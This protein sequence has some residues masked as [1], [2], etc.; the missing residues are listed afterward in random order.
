SYDDAAVHYRRSMPATAF[1]DAHRTNSDRQLRG[2]L[3]E[4]APAVL[5]RGTP[6]APRRRSRWIDHTHSAS[7]RLGKSGVDIRHVYIQTRRKHGTDSATITDHHDRIADPQL[8]GP[9]ELVFAFRFENIVEKGDEALAITMEDPHRDR[10]SAGWLEL[11][12]R[13][14]SAIFKASLSAAP[15]DRPRCGWRR[16][17]CRSP[18][19]GNCARC[20][21]TG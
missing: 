3:P 16:P 21:A 10:R 11:F 5:D 14:V 19:T 2:D 15:A 6:I 4:I 8:A 9:A 13:R 1:C 7:D 18:R 20:R 12:Q 17:V